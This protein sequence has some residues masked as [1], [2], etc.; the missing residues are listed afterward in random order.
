MSALILCIDDEHAIR[1]LV[2]GALE[3]GGFSVFEAET[4]LAPV[5][6]RVSLR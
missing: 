3:R 4:R 2:R 1:R 6:W 5:K